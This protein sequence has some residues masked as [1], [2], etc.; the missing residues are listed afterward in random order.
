[1]VLQDLQDLQDLQE[2]Q[3]RKFHQDRLVRLVHQTRHQV[4]R[5]VKMSYFITPVH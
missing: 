4:Q 5:E 2:T 3:V 1:M